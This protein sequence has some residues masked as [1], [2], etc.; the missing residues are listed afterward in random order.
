MSGRASSG[1]EDGRPLRIA[2]LMGGASEERGVSLASGCQVAA[3]LR[4]AGHE[5]ACVDPVAGVVPEEDEAR[6]LAAGISDADASARTWGPG[7]VASG[8]RAA[9]G[10]LR[11]ADVAFLALHGGAGEDGTVQAVLQASGIPYAGSGPAACALAMDKDLSKRLLRDAGVATPDWMVGAGA[12]ELAARRLGLPLVVKPVA[13]GSS[14]RLAVVSS[15]GEAEAAAEQAADSNGE[16]MYERYVKGR[17]FTVG[18]LE[19]EALPVVEI[20][21]ASDFFDFRCKYEPGMA[22]ETAPARIP[23]QLAAQLQS[24]ARRVHRALRLQH[25]SRV[26]FLVD[27]A[28]RPWCLEANAL[29][30]LTA[31]SLLPKAAQA[32]GIDFPA[33]CDRISRAGLQAGLR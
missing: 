18:I 21:P 13:G 31:A 20:E 22:V 10:V 27:E 25:F 33:L 12:G 11:D 1:R 24:V 29:P 6:I 8:L 4:E 32:A 3:A 19:E 14:V 9:N 28:G 7:A 5:V 16:A 17:E 30:G 26:D 23:Q 15:A 2:V